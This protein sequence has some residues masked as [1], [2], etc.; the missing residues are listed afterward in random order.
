MFELLKKICIKEKLVSIYSDYEETEK[1]FYGKILCVNEDEVLIY[2]I[3][4]SGKF[5]GILVKK[6]S[7]IFRIEYGGDYESKMELL[8]DCDLPDFDYPVDES[9]IGLSM[10]KNALET[11]EMI[12]IELLDSGIYDLIGIV[13]AIDKTTCRIKQY[14]E[15]GFEDGYSIINP[16]D[17]TQISYASQDEQ[18]IKRL[19]C[20]RNQL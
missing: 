5:D 11:K 1:F 19:M 10:L 2:L 6:T 4:P 15:Y 3:S 8:L 17:I 20:K 13:E 18:R 7:S 14:N 16:D 12:S 9:D